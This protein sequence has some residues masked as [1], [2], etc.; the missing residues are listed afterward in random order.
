MT[1]RAILTGLAVLAGS[2]LMSAACGSEAPAASFGAEAA[3]A[4]PTPT[5]ATNG[6]IYLTVSSDVAD[7]LVGA[8]VPTS[9]AASTELHATM[10]GDGGG[11]HSH[12]GDGGDGEMMSMGA[13]ESFPIAAGETLTFAPGGNHIMLIDVAEPLTRDNRFT[14]TLQFA[15]GRSLDVPVVVADNPPG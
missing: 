2:A 15:S 7:A 1:R 3:W 8:E 10:G 5:G 4:R 14:A 12:G 9:I 11:G 6:V 13:V